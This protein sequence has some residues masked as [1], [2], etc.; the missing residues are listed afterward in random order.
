MSKATQ[1]KAV[2]PKAM[3]QAKKEVVTDHDFYLM[4]SNGLINKGWKEDEIPSFREII[5]FKYDDKTVEAT[6]KHFHGS[7]KPETFFQENEPNEEQNSK[8]EMENLNPDEPPRMSNTTIQKADTQNGL[9]IMHVDMENEDLPDLDNADVVPFDMNATYWTPEKPGERR[10]V[11]FD[12]IKIA[13]MRDA[14]EPDVLVDLP[15]AF[16]YEK[17]G[18][19]TRAIRNASKRLIAILENNNLERGTPIQIE[20]VGKKKNSTNNYLSD[21]WSVKPLMIKINPKK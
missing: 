18:G 8:N 12:S 16:F 11:Y 5:P 20:Y 14:K 17:T 19:E 13:T 2:Q 15:C 10:R 6:V 4:V 7:P 9:G 3:Q 21:D 1:Q